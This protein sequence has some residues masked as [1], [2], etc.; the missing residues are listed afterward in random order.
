MSLPR[1][2]GPED[3]GSADSYYRRTFNPHYY[4]GG[5][6]TSERIHLKDMTAKEITA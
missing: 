6:H 5:T 2:G 4:K 1:H 3:R